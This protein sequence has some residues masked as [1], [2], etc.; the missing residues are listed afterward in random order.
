[1]ELYANFMPTKWL[2]LSIGYQGFNVNV[3]SY[4]HDYKMDITYSFKGPSAGISLKF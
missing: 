3:T 1:M 4:V 2:G